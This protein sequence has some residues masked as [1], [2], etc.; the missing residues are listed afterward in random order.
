MQKNL[1]DYL[2]NAK[3]TKKDQIDNNLNRTLNTKFIKYVN[4]TQLFI[5]KPYNE[6]THSYSIFIKNKVKMLVCP[7]EHFATTN[8]KKHSIHTLT[9][10]KNETNNIGDPNRIFSDSD[11]SDFQLA[12]QVYF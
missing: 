12:A 1:D 11:I 7:Y 6:R 5:P 2:E 9:K 8:T 4:D 3:C 10:H